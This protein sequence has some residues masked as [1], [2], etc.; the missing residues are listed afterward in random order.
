MEVALIIGL[1]IAGYELNRNGKQPRYKEPLINKEE[2]K[3]KFPFES[4]CKTRPRTI[5]EK[6]LKD[7]YKFQPFF[8]SAAKQNHN[9]NQIQQRFEM[10]TGTDDVFYKSKKEIEPMFKP[11][12]DVAFVNG[13]P[14][15][16]EKDRLEPYLNSLTPNMKFQNVS[17][18]EK[19]QIGPGLNTDDSAKGGFHQQ[20]RILPTNIGEQNLNQL[21]SRTNLGKSQTM[22]PT[23]R[24][25]MQQKNPTTFY[26]MESRPLEKGYSGISAPMAESKYIVQHTERGKVNHHPGILGG[27]NGSYT[28]YNNTRNKSKETTS[29]PGNPHM[30]STGAGGYTNNK[31]LV[32]QTNRENCAD[33]ELNASMQTTGSKVYNKDALEPTARDT[34]GCNPIVGN[35]Y[36]NK[37]Y[38]VNHG[39]GLKTTTKETTGC[40]NYTGQIGG[41]N[42]Q[43]ST[44]ATQNMDTFNKDLSTSRAPGPQNVN[45]RADPC[46]IVDN[47][48]QKDDKNV[49]R[50]GILKAHGI[51]NYGN[52]NQIGNI[53]TGPKISVISKN[54]DYNL[55]RNQIK[56]NPL[57]Q[58]PFS[59]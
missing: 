53:E 20:F 48:Y 45:I 55:V 43:S 32:H 2:R 52:V 46:E 31:Y 42:A 36:M 22:A 21:Q 27:Q 59:A 39:Y 4:D 33:N 38:E 57:I 51:N 3:N 13:T 18:V 28:Q 54:Q 25:A 24:Q 8:A 37:G 50:P 41:P 40:T 15:I 29:L 11:T 30:Q 49:Q 9:E 12:K 47:M 58:N 19:Q 14:N 7:N 16:S 26:E 10:F 23:N 6:I 34:T 56:D 35:P 44:Y 1:G 17:P 5:E